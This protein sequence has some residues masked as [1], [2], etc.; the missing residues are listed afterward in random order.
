MKA[1][2]LTLLRY[3]ALLLVALAGWVLA[4]VYAF[5][6]L[7]VEAYPDPSPPL[8][9]FI[10]QSR[11]W[12]AEEME[13][14]VTVPIEAALFGLPGLQYTRS[15]SLFGLSD[16]KLYFD[17][18]TDYFK[19]RQE[20]LNRIQ[21]V[22]LPNNLT[23]QLSP[24]SPVGEIYRYRLDGPGYSLNE[25]TAVQNWDVRR[26]LK[27]V[28]GIIDVTT[29]GGTTR[30]YQAEID[31]RRLLAFHVTLP[32]VLAA[33]SASNAN[34][35]GNY[36]TVGS[37]SV[38][39]RGVGLLQTLG[40]ME[41]VL[42]AERNG[43]PVFLKDIATVH[44]GIQPPLGR[45]GMD[46]DSS[47]V[48]GIVLLQRGEHSLPALRRLR[49]RVVA[50]NSGRL[51]PGMQL[52]TIYD[53]T[54]LIRVTTRTVMHLVVLGLA[55]VSGLLVV[56]LGD[57]SFALIT[58]LTIPVAILFAFG[59]MVVTGNAANLISIGAI[60]FG[61]LVDAAVV[62]VENIH[63]RLATRPG[64]APVA[65][66]IA[67]AT[68]D[69]ARPVV[70]STLVLLV[71][72]LPLF[73]MRGVP[74]KIFAPMS[75]T[76]GF[77][78]T[79]A[80]LYALLFAPVLASWV[81]PEAS[82]LAG[83]TRLTQ[84]VT[85][86]YACLLPGVLRHRRAVL[87]TAGGALAVALAVLRLVGA[88][89][90]PK[91]E[92]GNL[93]I[94]ATLPVDISYEAAAMLAD[95]I[96]H[97]LQGFPPVTHVVSHLGRPDDGTDVTTFN[98]IEFFVQLQPQ[99]AWPPGFTKAK[100]VAQMATT[101]REFPGVAFGFSQ[102][103]ED[104]VEEAMSGVKGENS[105]KLF[106]DDLEE[107]ARTAAR[108]RAILAQVP[109]I[110]DLAILQETGQP[111][112]VVAIDRGASARYGLTAAD[113]NAA[114]QAA[115]GGQ[116][117]TQI[118]QGERRFDFVVRYA[119][120]YRT[121][122]EAIRHIELPTPEGGRVPLGQVAQVE[123]RQGAFMIFREN[124]KRYVPI[125]F[126]VRGRDLAATIEDAQARLQTAV[127][128]PVGYY[129]EW[130]GE[131]ES[132]R[133][134]ERRLAVVIPVS[135]ALIVVLLYTLFNSWRDA[136]LVLA[137]LPFGAIGG[138]LSLLVTG[139]PFSISA[140]VGFT[141]ALGVATLGGCVF[142]SGIRRVERSSPPGRGAGGG[143]AGASAALEA[144]Q[145]GA[146]GELRPVLMACLAAGLGLLP[147]AIST[148]IGA[149][150]QQPLARVVV[151]AMVTTAAAIG[152]LLPLFASLGHRPPAGGAS[153]AASRA[154][155]RGPAGPGDDGTTARTDG[156]R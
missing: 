85:G 101:L 47:V 154:G 72:F 14:Q 135:L 137:I 61:I 74:G 12:S 105:L 115:I 127:H 151:G 53:R 2:V 114:V 31:P 28:P 11:A 92:E 139:T 107:L 54:D 22:T 146:L 79:G 38:N 142:L 39:V 70:F 111:E 100:L 84:W 5:V 113:V 67:Q 155:G 26:E 150:A 120:P 50:L 97:T 112:L 156:T 76:Y 104:N 36:L 124:G 134:E 78:L 110:H 19:D 93:W 51:P 63:R 75:L 140:A 89:F 13:R 35:G 6:R 44:E 130:T 69:A 82:V 103:I 41:H 9:E 77:A 23:P 68:A 152:V 73:T 56:F 58:A 18:G 33:V 129:Y 123:L 121:T 45:V 96:R 90:M 119:P 60:D 66:L 88:E 49:E 138:V 122:P 17:Y 145:Q 99:G 65:D 3:R 147:A 37:Q 80:L 24:W 95:D 8:V 133:R 141:S 87:A 21:A 94:R 15:I 52:H 91:L 4:G 126:S 86:A 1:F 153:L 143:A 125:K 71:A 29:F 20:A 59:A 118:V 30:Q 48:E 7:D 10:T 32:E 128:L 40:D 16:V 109:G 42:V 149:Q 98:N 34:V 46:A 136:G 81:P 27:E 64:G 132:L 83:P 102:N 108:I 57:L 62:V 55:F 25:L 117:S 116:A 43:A 148:G 144:L 131:Y 106:G